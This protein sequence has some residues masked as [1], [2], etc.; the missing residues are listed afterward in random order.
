MKIHC[1]QC[2]T[3]FDREVLRGDERIE[4]PHCRGSFLVN[5][6]DTVLYLS[7][8]AGDADS[9]PTTARGSAHLE[10]GQRLG[11]FVIDRVVGEGGMGVVYLGT[12]VSLGKKVAI[13][14]LPPTLSKNA[15]FV[16]RFDREAQALAAL[17]HPNIVTIIDKGYT[18]GLYYFVMEY[19]EGI[20]LRHLM[21]ERR[22]TPTEALRIVPAVCSA[23]EY[24][25]E[26]GIVHRDVK[27]ENILITADGRVKIADFG[28][29]KILSGE[30]AGHHIT[31][32]QTTVGTFEYM[33]PEQRESSRSVDPRADLYSLGV[34]FYEMLTGELPIGRFPPPSAKNGTISPE[35]DE[36][37]MRVLDKDPDRRFQRASE[38]ADEIVRASQ[39]RAAVLPLLDEEEP[40]WRQ[41]ARRGWDVTREFAAGNKGIVIATLAILCFAPH[42]LG[43]WVFAAGV[44]FFV[45]HNR[46]SEKDSAVSSSPVPVPP[47][48]DLPILTAAPPEP[49]PPK[50]SLAC[51]LAFALGGFL[52]GAYTLIDSIWWPQQMDRFLELPLPRMAQALVG[53]AAL[54]STGLLGM[55]VGLSASAR[56]KNRKRRGRWLARFGTLF[57]FIFLTHVTA[58]WSDLQ[59]EYVYWRDLETQLE[60]GEGLEDLVERIRNQP[61]SPRLDRHV[62]VLARFEPTWTREQFLPEATPY[63]QGVILDE[64]ARSGDPVYLGDIERLMLPP[65]DARTREAAVQSLRHYPADVAVP[66]YA[67]YQRAVEPHLDAGSRHAV[68]RE[69]LAAI[70]CLRPMREPEALG[71]LAG[72]VDAED[73]GVALA[74]CEAILEYAWP[75]E[76]AAIRATAAVVSNAPTPLLRKKAARRL[77]GLPGDA[78][79]SALID[80]LGDRDESVRETCIVALRAR[81]E[82]AYGYDPALSPD[83][84]GNVQAIASFRQLASA[85]ER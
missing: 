10:G 33:A 58:R 48:P 4:C 22:L 77:A 71:V 23:L 3:A 49:P 84:P 73:R 54:G 34:I 7:T 12:Q 26:R 66:A 2:Q 55:L 45:R 19:V 59:A 43:P 13:K 1:P 32:T 67:R 6:K 57:S 11:G 40:A 8:A 46:G 16:R 38:V 47:V 81:Y 62:R 25:H 14:V 64:F 70:E 65:A 72:W 30:G 60:R 52:I 63:V 69:V 31:R 28:L 50:G 76:P 35:I 80:G 61:E 20:T 75:Q 29:S 78:G 85:V 79:V 5:S 74:A 36:I 18:A 21:R 17:N 56:A 68:R 27:P 9:G 41:W 51:W 83:S 53:V 15:E 82:T 42:A 24:A 39:P 37:V 44:Y